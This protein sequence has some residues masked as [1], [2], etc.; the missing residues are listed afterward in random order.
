MAI[1]HLV[2][3]D[4]DLISYKEAE[5]LLKATPHPMSVTTLKRLVARHRLDVTRIDRAVHVSFSDLLEAHRDE[6]R[7]RL[8]DPG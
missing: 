3:A 2:P 5:A 6:V 8:S 7:R 1:H 4:C